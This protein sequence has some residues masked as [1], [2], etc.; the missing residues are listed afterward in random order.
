MFHILRVQFF[1]RISKF[2]YYVINMCL[3]TIYYIKGHFTAS[4]L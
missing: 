4:Y 3:P 1:P 2:K